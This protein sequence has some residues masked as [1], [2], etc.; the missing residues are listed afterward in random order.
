MR[1]VY[2]SQALRDIANILAYVYKRESKRALTAFRSPSSTPSTS[3]RY[4]PE[5]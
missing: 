4:I 5:P 3:A 1:I 2:A